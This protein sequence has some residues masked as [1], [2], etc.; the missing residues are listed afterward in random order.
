MKRSMNVISTDGARLDK[1]PSPEDFFVELTRQN[2]KAIISNVLET[3]PPKQRAVVFYHYAE[4]CSFQEIAERM[5]IA[6]GTA[7]KHHARA[8]ERLGHELAIRSI[9][10]VR[11]VF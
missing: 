6:I 7:L 5:D 2:A 3:L 10:S 1:L 9:R 11:D 4:G 8:L